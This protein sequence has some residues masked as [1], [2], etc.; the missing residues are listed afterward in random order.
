MESIE[1]RNNNEANLQFLKK[2][3]KVFSNNEDLSKYI[4]SFRTK[5]KTEMCKNWELTG[6]CEFLHTCSFAHGYHELQ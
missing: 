4:D 6:Y 1:Q 3:K 2:Q 5:Y